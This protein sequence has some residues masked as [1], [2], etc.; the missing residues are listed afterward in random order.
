MAGD[1]ADRA[2]RLGELARFFLWLGTVGFGGP[3]AH[4]ALLEEHAV[5]R[6]R[7]LSPRDFLDLVGL[8]NLIPGPNSTELAMAIGYRRAGL[9]GLVVAGASFILPAACLTTLLAWVYTKYGSLP[10]VSIALAGLGPGVLVLMLQGVW[11]LGRSGV[12][13]AFD[14]LCA[15]A[16]F[17]LVLSGVDEVLLLA[18][19]ALVG[20][21]ADVRTSA[22]ITALLWTTSAVTLLAHSPQKGP[23]LFEIGTFF[24][25]VG[26]VLYGGG[27][28]LIAFLERL[29]GEYHWLS[30]AQVIDA[31]AAGQI[32]P[33]PVLTT[34]TF[35][36]YVLRGVPGAAVATF[37]IFLPAF[38]LTA[39]LGRV[40]PWLQRSA[41]ARRA[42]HLVSVAAIAL[43]AAAT[44]SLAPDVLRRQG[45]LVPLVCASVVALKGAG[46]VWILAA[47]FLTGAVM[48]AIG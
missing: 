25:R 16:V 32:T 35:V 41:R 15:L 19:A 45:M 9:S 37:A 17:A 2:A 40:A 8:T 26:A 10:G 42:V 38:I 30:H 4:I 18:G 28:V 24:L 47:G 48:A 33:G 29:A 22:A 14:V 7:W 46:G 6:R 3:A 34:A 5:R 20:A 27:Y 36:G 12:R 44:V 13:T 39:L 1:A 11:R 43:L 31:V 21:I 23:S